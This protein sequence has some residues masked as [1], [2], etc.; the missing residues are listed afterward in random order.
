MSVI[1]K[2]LRD[3][4]SRRP[5]AES[6]QGPP[7]GSALS[8]VDAGATV[9]VGGRGFASGSLTGQKQ[10]SW[11]LVVAILTLLTAASAVY[12][13]WQTRT[14]RLTPPVLRQ[15]AP[16]APQSSV[17][18]EFAPVQPAGVATKPDE[19]RDHEVVAL[20][21][22]NLKET[23]EMVLPQGK[24]RLPAEA[25]RQPSPVA[26]APVATS[27]AVLKPATPAAPVSPASAQSPRPR[28]HPAV[29]EVLAQAQSY[30][31]GG[32][33]A[34]AVELLQAAITRLEQAPG[35]ETTPLASVVREYARM[36]LAQGQ[37]VEVLLLL[38]RLEPRL[39]G[40]ADIWAI[41]GNTAQRLGRHQ[42]ASQAYLKG[43]ALRPEE[44]RWM[45]GAAISMAALG[46]VVPATELAEKARLTGALRPDVAN[47]LRQ[48]GVQVR[49]D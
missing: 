48:L 44:P 33:H 12:W 4:D 20:G 36:G 28:P 26:L 29:T 5:V 40:V 9:S 41:R 21:K 38:E 11:R 45:L 3:L 2:M 27:S 25:P 32:A 14:I 16:V 39:A 24:H 19:K 1:N 42:E 47:Y 6:G 37:A 46:Q 35:S 7:S 34:A 15:Q 8:D 13:W 10:G 17:P 31:S 43:L 49:S 23:L 30:W 22:A 18:A